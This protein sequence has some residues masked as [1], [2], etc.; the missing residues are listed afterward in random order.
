MTDFPAF[1]IGEPCVVLQTD[2]T[3]P[4]GVYDKDGNC[5]IKVPFKY[6]RPDGIVTMKPRKDDE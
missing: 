3:I 1:L 5:V 4:A 6:T 2:H